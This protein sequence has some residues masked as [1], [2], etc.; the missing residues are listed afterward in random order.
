MGF[1]W[2]IAKGYVTSMAKKSITIADNFMQDHVEYQ[3]QDE[4]VR[5][6]IRL[7][8]FA[9]TIVSLA[10]WPITILYVVLNWDKLK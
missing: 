6:F 7:G 5:N 9:A 3:F 1:I 8:T 10:L 4:L 2:F